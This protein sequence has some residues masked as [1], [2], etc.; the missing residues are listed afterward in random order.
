MAVHEKGGKYAKAKTVISAV[1]CD[2]SGEET[3]EQVGR[4]HGRSSGSEEEGRR[5]DESF[6]RIDVYHDVLISHHLHLGQ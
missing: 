4:E 1:S 6:P 5:L 2:G 3:Y